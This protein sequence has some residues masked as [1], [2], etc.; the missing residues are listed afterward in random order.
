MSLSNDDFPIM[1]N[2]INPIAI[3]RDFLK[4]KGADLDSVEIKKLIK[5]FEEMGTGDTEDI[6]ATIDNF[7]E[8]IRA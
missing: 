8:E 1:A 4:G 7:L 2:E 5:V 3:F 6:E